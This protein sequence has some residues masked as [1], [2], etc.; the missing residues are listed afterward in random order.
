MTSLARLQA[1]QEV[2]RIE[3]IDVSPILQQLCEGIRP[4]AQQRR[5]FLRCDGPPGYAVDGDA[6]KIRRI[7]QNL[8]AQCR[9]VYPQRR[10]HGELGR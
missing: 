5:L 3:P 8:H 9:Q 1:G 7:A 6:V 4:L 10:R 2:R